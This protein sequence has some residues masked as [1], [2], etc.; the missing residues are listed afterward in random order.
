MYITS[1][2]ER[3]NIAK[4]LF[5]IDDGSFQKLAS[6]FKCFD[7]LVTP[8]HSTNQRASTGIN[9]GSGRPTHSK[10]D[11]LAA[12]RALKTDPDLTRTRLQSID[13]ESRE[14]D[15]DIPVH[16]I[17]AAVHLAVHLMLMVDISA[18]EKY[19]A[20]YSFSGVKPIKWND[21]EAFHVFVSR[22]F[23][24]SEPQTLEFEGQ[25][26][27]MTAFSLQ[28]YGQLKFVP[29][30]NLVDHLLL[31]VELGEVRIFHHTSFL[32]AQLKVLKAETSI[33]GCLKRFVSLQCY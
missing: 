14:P 18:A 1:E 24:Q 11:I 5:G 4:E 28:K 15:H 2:S 6:Y 27:D 31:D 32:K 23:S 7:T 21:D 9:V 30:D 13:F 19:T 3:E 25:E 16:N 8:H 26:G 20:D 22:A 10:F 17:G 29:T 33:L 12:V